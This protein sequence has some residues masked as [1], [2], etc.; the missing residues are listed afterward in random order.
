MKKLIFFSLLIL[1]ASLQNVYCQDTSGNKILWTMDLS[2]YQIR[3]TRFLSDDNYFVNTLFTFLQKRNTED[4][5]LVKEIE[6][7]NQEIICIDV[8]KEGKF[9]AV[10]GG[11]M[12]K[13]IEPENLTIIKEFNPENFK[14]GGINKLSLSPD[15]K[16]IAFNCKF[17]E[18]NTTKTTLKILDIDSEIL[19][20]EENA[21]SDFPWDWIK[22]SPNGKY[23]ACT[24]LGMFDGQTWHYRPINVYDM[25]NVKLYYSYENKYGDVDELNFAKD[26]NILAASI[27]GIL[28]MFDLHDKKI[29]LS[30]T[31]MLGKY[32]M[33]IYSFQIF[34]DNKTFYLKANNGYIYD[35][36]N[37]KINFDYG[38]SYI[39]HP[40]FNKSENKILGYL[41]TTLGIYSYE[42]ITSV[43][44]QLSDTEIIYPNPATNLITIK[45]DLP[46]SSDLELELYDNS[47]SEIS[48]ILKKFYESGAFEYQFPI[49]NLSV[50]QYFLNLTQKDF[51]KWFKFIKD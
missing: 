30:D 21:E 37:R 46:Y 45:I 49:D 18:P 3:G 41:G 47:G 31:V 23:L 29:I 17:Y 48:A 19:L 32:P 24:Q 35:I 40:D 20:Y 38:E 15:G 4:G 28:C 22:F 44:K 50:G 13:L 2:P 9:I 26:G 12:L 16:K 33:G 5:E 34:S 36:I 14:Y 8:S 10:G 6:I 27:E 11:V 51:V 42:K 39:S 43:F 25:D 1:F 7:P